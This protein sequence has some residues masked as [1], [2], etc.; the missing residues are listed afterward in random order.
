ML[1]V[2]KEETA[3][4]TRG[5]QARTWVVPGISAAVPPPPAADWRRAQH[6]QHLPAR[7]GARASGSNL[8]DPQLPLE[9]PRTSTVSGSSSRRLSS[10]SLSSKA[11]VPATS[12]LDW[13]GETGTGTLGF[14]GTSPAPDS[15]ALEPKRSPRTSRQ[16]ASYLVPREKRV[17]QQDGPAGLGGH[18]CRGALHAALPEPEQP[19]RL[20][21]SSSGLLSLH[22]LPG[23]RGRRWGSLFPPLL[24]SVSVV[25]P[26]R[27]VAGGLAS[28]KNFK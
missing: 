6:Q 4:S 18:G 9:T 10:G 24:D 1:A 15:P 19:L 17:L 16:D 23:R 14:R 28:G 3:A 11:K 20:L 5:L 2:P 13:V 12:Q 21:W 26:L 7:E 27:S 22:E 25:D 8:R